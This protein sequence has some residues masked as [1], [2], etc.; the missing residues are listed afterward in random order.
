[1]SELSKEEKKKI[2]KQVKTGEFSGF[3][4]QFNAGDDKDEPNIS[5]ILVDGILSPIAY[6]IVLA[7]IMHF[8]YADSQQPMLQVQTFQTYGCQRMI[9]DLENNP[10]SAKKKYGNI[11]IKVIGCKVSNIGQDGVVQV[12]PIEGLLHTSGLKLKFREDDRKYVERLS[13][14][15]RCVI[16]GR[17]ID[18]T[19]DPFPDY[20]IDVMNMSAMGGK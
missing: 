20:V 9:D 8:I 7:V 13:V 14:G 1:M 12:N 15:D 10:L 17:V 11:G 19:D 16:W 6:L 5:K 4:R 3:A 2:K 18:V